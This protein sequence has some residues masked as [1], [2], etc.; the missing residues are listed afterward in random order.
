MRCE[1]LWQDMLVAQEWLQ[2]GVRQ[3]DVDLSPTTTRN[4][5][6]PQPSVSEEDPGL[7][8]REEV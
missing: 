2:T 7:Q 4:W 3:R 6:P 1:G 8:I 5:I